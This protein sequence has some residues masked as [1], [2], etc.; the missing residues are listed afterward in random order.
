MVFHANNKQKSIGG[1]YIKIQ[2]LKNC[3]KHHYISIAIKV[4]GSLGF[5]VC[6][7]VQK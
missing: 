6:D 2:K 1:G 3:Y 7:I 4:W 5:L